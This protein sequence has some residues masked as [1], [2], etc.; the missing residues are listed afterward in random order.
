MEHPKELTFLT[1]RISELSFDAAKGKTKISAS[2]MTPTKNNDVFGGDYWHYS[3][4]LN[5]PF[6]TALEEFLY[7]LAALENAGDDTHRNREKVRSW[8]K[9][10]SFL[11]AY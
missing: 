6:I 9:E 8:M 10:N 2:K 1:W 7:S 4:N 3:I 5:K 11:L